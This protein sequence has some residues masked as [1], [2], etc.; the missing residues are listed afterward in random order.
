MG[1]STPDQSRAI[2]VRLKRKGVIETGHIKIIFGEF[3][4]SDL[5]QSGLRNFSRLDIFL[6]PFHLSLMGY[7]S[8]GNLYTFI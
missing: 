8:D 3:V 1:V 7:K 4:I 6:T 2:C 5:H